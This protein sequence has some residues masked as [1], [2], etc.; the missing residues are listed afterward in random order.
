MVQ[1][2]EKK[3]LALLNLRR[4]RKLN[5]EQIQVL[6]KTIQPPTVLGTEEKKTETAVKRISLLKTLLP[7]VAEAP[8]VENT[9]G[10]E[11]AARTKSKTNAI[12]L[13]RNDIIKFQ[14]KHGDDWVTARVEGR[15]GKVTG[16]NKNYFNIQQVDGNFTGGVDLD[17]VA[18]WEKGANAIDES[19][20]SVNMVLVPYNR[21][22]EKECKEAKTA[23]LDKLK[24]FGIYEVVKDKGQTKISMKW[25]LWWKE[26]EI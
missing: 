11:R 24:T 12:N 25:V 23:E 26:T 2:Q 18:A 19:V 9:S 1:M 7:I 21:H 5:Q 8:I 4:R 17:K 6:M 20:E 13:K 16:G 3:I 15:A 10:I 22:D 14:D